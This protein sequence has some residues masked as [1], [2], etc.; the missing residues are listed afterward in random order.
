MDAFGVGVRRRS[1][2]EPS[3]LRARPSSRSSPTRAPPRTSSPRLRS[4]AAAS[5]SRAS[6]ADSIQGDV[7]SSTC[8]SG[9]ARAVERTPPRDHRQRHRLAARRRRRH[10][11][12]LR[13]GADAR[14]RGRR[15]PTT[16]TRVR[17]VG[18]IRAKETD[19]IGDLVTE[20][21]AR[22]R[23]RARARRTASRSCPGP[24]R[25]DALSHLR[26]PPHGDE[27]GAA[28]PARPGDRDRGPGLRREDLP[29][30]LRRPRAAALAAAIVRD[31]RRDRRPGRG[32]QVDGRA[33]RRRGAR[34]PLPRQRRDVPLRRAREPRGP[35]AQRRPSTRRRST[36]RSASGCCSAGAT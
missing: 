33:R 29:G 25:P 12:H 23:R 20:L 5:R 8:S 16:P 27:P 1:R 21:R 9:W 7:A 11:R 22:R 19:R 2:V 4:A 28:R 34:L 13:H 10:G 6:G 3:A 32:R 31:D 35:L 30:L 36:S 26:R 17:G 18:F 15:S 24:V 14:R